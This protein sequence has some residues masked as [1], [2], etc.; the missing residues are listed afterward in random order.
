M[1]LAHA[2]ERH[3]GEVTVVFAGEADLSTVRDFRDALFDALAE[4]PARVVIDLRGLIFIDST[5]VSALIAVRQAALKQG[6][7]LIVTYP[8]GQVLRVLRTAGV[9]GTL[10]ADRLQYEGRPGDDAPAEGL[11][12]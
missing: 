3:D 7:Q 9:L 5:G 10:T 2:V 1:K 12:A 4:R 6:A 8:R 11:T